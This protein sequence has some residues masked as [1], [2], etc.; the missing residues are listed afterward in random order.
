MDSINDEDNILSY[1]K[2][3]EKG[4]K[5]IEDKMSKYENISIDVNAMSILIYTSGTTSNPKAVMLSQGNICSNLSAM[6]TLI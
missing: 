1:S 2:L 6:T 3:V 5:L 4:K